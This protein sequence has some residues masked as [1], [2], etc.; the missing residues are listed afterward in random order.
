MN[1]DNYCRECRRFHDVGDHLPS[2]RVWEE[3]YEHSEGTVRALDASAAA[4]RWAH[5]DDVE[6]AE[7]GI[8]GGS[9]VIVVVV[10]CEGVSVRFKVSGESVPEYTAEVLS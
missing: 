3:G 5:D 10:D 6:T 7:Y 9:P 8:V 2:W 1:L 4:E